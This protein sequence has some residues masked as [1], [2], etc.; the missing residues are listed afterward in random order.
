MK[1]LREINNFQRDAWG[2]KEIPFPDVPPNDPAQVARFFV[3]RDE[4]Y[5]KARTHLYSGDNVLV[6]GTWG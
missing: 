4:E 2:L 1:S 3:G 6:R 5:Q